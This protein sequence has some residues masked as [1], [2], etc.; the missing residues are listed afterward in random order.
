MDR[1]NPL[2]DEP[3]EWSATATGSLRIFH[4]GRLARVVDGREA[5]KLQLK[6]EAAEDD[7][8]QQ[9]LAR[10]TGQFKFGNERQGKQRRR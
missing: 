9:L 7:Q 8:V 5:V 10:A 6:L 4:R 1:D 3:F 2:A